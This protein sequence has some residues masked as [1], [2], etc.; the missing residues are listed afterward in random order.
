MAIDNDKLNE[1]PFN[2][3]NCLYMKIFKQ[4]GRIRSRCKLGKNMHEPE[5]GWLINGL[6]KKIPVRWSFAIKCDEFHSLLIEEIERR[7]ID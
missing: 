5:N 2:C 1:Q 6:G 3:G 7:E 4:E